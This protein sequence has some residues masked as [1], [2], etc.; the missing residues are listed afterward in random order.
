MKTRFLTV[1]CTLAILLA[2]VP[3]ASA[4]EDGSPEAIA[5]DIIVVRP[6]CFVMT[7]IG[8][9]L[10]VVALPV[11]AIS[12]STHATADA[13]VVKPAHATFTRPWGNMTDL[14]P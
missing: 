9:A 2:H 3:P 5:A 7:I 14:E 10:F 11:A 6:A 4:M 13:L 12:H 1:L 8:S